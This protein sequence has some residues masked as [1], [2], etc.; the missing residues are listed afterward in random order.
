MNLLRSTCG[1]QGRLGKK[2]KNNKAFKREECGTGHPF[3]Q[4]FLFGGQQLEIK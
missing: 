3:L 1:C 4:K 2:N